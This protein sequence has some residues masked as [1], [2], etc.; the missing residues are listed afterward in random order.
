MKEGAFN[1][2][3]KCFLGKMI[4]DSHRNCYLFTKTDKKEVDGTHKNAFR[5]DSS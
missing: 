3:R 5:K 2:A 1:F 4:S